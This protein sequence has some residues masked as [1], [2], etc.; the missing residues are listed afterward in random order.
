[1]R[2]H[3]RFQPG[4]CRTATDSIRGGS[5]LGRLIRQQA[6]RATNAKE[7]SAY[8]GWSGACLR[9]AACSMC[10]ALLP[11]RCDRW[12]ACNT[13]HR[14]LTCGTAPSG[15]FCDRTD[16]LTGPLLVVTGVQ[17]EACW[18]KRAHAIWRLARVG[19]LLAVSRR[20]SKGSLDRDCAVRRDRCDSLS[21]DR[22]RRCRRSVEPPRAPSRDPRRSGIV[23]RAAESKR[24]SIERRKGRWCIPRLRNC[25]LAR[26]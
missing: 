1:V 25:D 19:I 17:R 22:D 9:P 20:R 8:S 26:Q 2:A 24:A 13:H 6:G 5:V 4:R 18:S 11:Q 15:G 3:R 21:C 12:C 7:D 23:E 14:V 10:G 16:T